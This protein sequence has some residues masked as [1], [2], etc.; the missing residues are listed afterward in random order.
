LN[1]LPL[2]HSTTSATGCFSAEATRR[3]TGRNSLWSW[4]N[5]EAVNFFLLCRFFLDRILRGV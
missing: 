5:P 2:A 1:A 3:A 4:L